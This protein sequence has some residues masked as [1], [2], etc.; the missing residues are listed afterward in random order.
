M[1]TKILLGGLVAVLVLTFA[2]VVYLRAA[3]PQSVVLSDGSRLTVL[4][5]TYGKKHTLAKSKVGG[6]KVNG[7]SITTS[8]DSVC[9]WIEQQHPQNNWP[10]YQLLVFD[11]DNTGCARES[12]RTFV[13]LS[14][15]RKD[16][17]SNLPA[18]LAKFFG[19]AAGGRQNDEIMGFVFSA[20]PRRGDKINFRIQQWN[21]QNGQ[22]D[23]SATAF[24][25]RNPAPRGAYPKWVP[26][27]LP[28]TQQDGDLQITLSRFETEAN[29]MNPYGMSSKPNDP[30][31]RGVLAAFHVEQGGV[32]VTNWQP[33]EIETTD[34]TGNSMK[35][36]SWN[37]PRESDEEVMH[38]QWG[39]WPEE[40]AWKLR[41]EMSR[42]SGYSSAET[43]TAPN[44]PLKQ[45]NMNDMFQQN[46]NN[47]PAA[48]TT[49]GE[50]QLELF[51][52]IQLTADSR[53]NFGNQMEGVFRVRFKT[54]PEGLRLNVVQISDDQ[55]RPIEFGNWGWGGNEYRFSLKHLGDAKSLNITLAVHPSRFVEFTAKP[56]KN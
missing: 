31:S 54:M 55:N 10:N 32:L 16:W 48:E 45:G 28:V 33:I 15:R 40:P 29:A 52:P 17:Y 22:Q 46:R 20:F 4:D 7:G 19:P 14:G 50:T 39:L 12:A 2:A 25:I 5:V 36:R 35:S 26:E 30:M 27:P 13:N 43:W 44:I 8:N 23:M 21:N 9:V 1:K 49:I 37:S 18:W 24:S 41:V 38:Y 42:T 53:R 47:K 3:Q 11:T 6:R 51:P 56:A 34:A